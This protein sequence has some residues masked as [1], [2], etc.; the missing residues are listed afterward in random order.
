MPWVL[1]PAEFGSLVD[2]FFYFLLH[3]CWLLLFSVDVLALCL[4]SQHSVL[5]LISWSSWKPANKSLPTLSPWT[6]ERPVPTNV[7]LPCRL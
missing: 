5:S 3:C 4:P 1:R 2:S 7:P 6:A